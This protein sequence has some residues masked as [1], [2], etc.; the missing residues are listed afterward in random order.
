MKLSQRDWTMKPAAAAG[1][2][3]A[4]LAL[5]GTSLA[6]APAASA[7]AVP[8]SAAVISGEFDAVSAASPAS[9]WAVGCAIPDSELCASDL[10]DHW[11]GKTWT[12]VAVPSPAGS[13]GVDVGLTSVTDISATDAWAIGTTEGGSNYV[14][15]VHWNGKSWS[16]TTAPSIG[17]YGTQYALN[18]IS[19]ASATSIW[20]AGSIG[21]D[22]LVLH[23]NGKAWSQ[24]PVPLNPAEAASGIYS[25]KAI[26][27][28][29]VWAVGA[30]ASEPLIL[31]WNGKSWA[32]LESPKLLVD[33]DSRLTAVA[34][35]SASNVWAVGYGDAN[36]AIQFHWNGKSWS[37]ETYRGSL[38]LPGFG[39]ELAG[40][41]TT[42][43]SSA[44]AAAC[45]GRALH[46]NGKKWSPAQMGTTAEDFPGLAGA[47][48]DS[49]WATGWLVIGSGDDV[50]VILHWNGKTWTRSV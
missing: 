11:N 43:S 14:Q 1:A 50:A 31:H 23:W 20:A 46:W 15:I 9:A 39:Y 28:S 12:R 30:V 8:A 10:A 6:A 29:D 34:G 17:L 33:S 24:V 27:A 48:S 13:F 18:A 40:V 4:G 3:L 21:G 38:P 47:S 5:A 22:A 25:V 2:V 44:W 41:E 37:N 16:Q 35:S 19:A 45:C 42:S 36:T 7:S 26:S 49:V 32:R